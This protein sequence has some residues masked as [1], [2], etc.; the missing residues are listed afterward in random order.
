MDG[1]FVALVAVIMIFGI[2]TAAT[3][4]F[5]RVRKRHKRR[6][7]DSDCSKGGCADAGETLGSST[8]A[9]VGTLLVAE[10]IGYFVTFVLIGREE[11]KAMIAATS[12]LIPLTVGIGF[13]VDHDLLRRDR[14]TS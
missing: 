6:T 9:S 7:D 3:Y 14:R 5:F 1:N 11:L 13:L 8:F 4:T 12:D 2:P 10:A